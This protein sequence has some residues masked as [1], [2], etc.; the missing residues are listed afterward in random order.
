MAERASLNRKQ[1]LILLPYLKNGDGTA[2]ALMNYYQALI[3][4]NWNV[5]FLNLKNNDCEW[6]QMVKKNGGQ[7]YEIPQVNKYSKL[8]RK[9]IEKIINAKNYDI[10]HVNIPG[11]V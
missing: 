4:D 8:V 11:H 1:V 2:V 6:S 7:I 3:K 9:Y 10:V 5:D